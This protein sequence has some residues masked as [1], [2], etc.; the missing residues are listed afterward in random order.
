MITIRSAK[1]S[2][3]DA[4]WA[5][6]EPVFR[7]GDT[8]AIDAGI[9]RADALA[10]WCGPDQETF[11]AEADGAVLGTYYMRPNQRGGGR[12][13]CNCGYVTAR[14]AQGRGIA[15][16]MLEHSLGA[17]P[18]AGFRAM[19]YNF[20]VS[21]NSRAVALWRAYGFRIVGVIAQGFRHPEQGYVDAYVMYRALNA[22]DPE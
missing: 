16:A 1:R 10:Y 12:H 7:A 21:T 9:G 6:L 14:A 22:P 5:I 11:V 2:D 3:H 19:Q 18:R 8:Y 17:A 13:V 4:I 15:R 20:V